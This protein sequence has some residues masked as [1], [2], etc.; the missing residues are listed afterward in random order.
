MN[1]FVLSCFSLL[2]K[3]KLTVAT[4]LSTARPK[5]TLSL[6]ERY[7]HIYVQYILG[8]FSIELNALQFGNQFVKLHSFR[9]HF[10]LLFFSFLSFLLVLFVSLAYCLNAFF[11]VHTPLRKIYI[12]L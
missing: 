2:I 5:R 4:A 9:S 12:Y 7:A 6:V 10:L 11:D 3:F 1:N 8:S